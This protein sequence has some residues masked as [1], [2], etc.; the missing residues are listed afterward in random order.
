MVEMGS[1]HSL[2]KVNIDQSLME[3]VSRVKDMERI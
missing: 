2:T 1:A 3:L